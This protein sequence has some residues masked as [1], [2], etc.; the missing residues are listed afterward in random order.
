MSRLLRLIPRSEVGVAV[1]E[2]TTLPLFATGLLGLG[3][4]ALRR[5]RL[6]S[7]LCCSASKWTTST[8]VGSASARLLRSTTTASGMSG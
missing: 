5:R 7:A 1:P 4:V 2:P 8:I 6:R 3:L